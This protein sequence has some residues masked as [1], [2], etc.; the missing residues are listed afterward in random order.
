[1]LAPL[2]NRAIL[3]KEPAEGHHLAT[4]EKENTALRRALQKARSSQKRMITLNANRNLEQVQRIGELEALVAQLR[5]RLNQLE[6]GQAMLEMG[7]RLVALQHAND[8]LQ[9]A[10]HRVWHLDKTLC[11][12]HR[13]CERL[14]RERDE[15]AARL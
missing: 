11:A 12:A 15:L 8:E 10:A 5:S 2:D 13:E 6:S 1:M 14:A 4:L 3:E 7:R 9:A